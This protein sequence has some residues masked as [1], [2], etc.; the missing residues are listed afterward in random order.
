[1]PK[2]SDE[3]KAERREQILAGARSCFAENGYEG[4][5]VVRLEKAIGLSRGAIFNY[6]PSKE[7]LFLEL[8]WRDNERLIRLWLDR[9]WEAALRAVVEEDPDWLGVYLEMTRKI[10]TD[11]DFAR[12]HEER[13][14]PELTKAL[15][16]KVR[17]EQE[18]G[19]VRTDYPPERVAGFI[20]LVA[21]G[22]VLQM[23]FGEPIRDV[24]ALVGF[25]RTAVEPSQAPS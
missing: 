20:S 24:D 23:A 13:A 8:A 6:F 4:A 10:R 15:I 2:I 1:V 12:R 3:R 14:D 16:E 22:V 9:G 17:T 21:N 19:A 11:P 25:V 7:D 18:Q 5:T